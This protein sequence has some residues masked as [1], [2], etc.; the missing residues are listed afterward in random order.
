VWRL[1]LDDFKP[2]KL[3]M[4]VDDRVVGKEAAFA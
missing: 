2:P 1:K 3:E 4:M